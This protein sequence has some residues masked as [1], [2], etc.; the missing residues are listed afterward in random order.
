MSD[1][2]VKKL[3]LLQHRFDNKWS[4]ISKEFLGKSQNL[5]KNT[6]FSTI[7][8]NIR[9]FNRNKQEFERISGPIHELLLI[10]EIRTILETEKSPS[11]QEIFNS[12]LS[13]EVLHTTQKLNQA[14]QENAE[15]DDFEIN[16]DDWLNL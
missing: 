8:R 11:K 15:I 5:L 16:P 14:V 2:D 6:F 10:P 12:S 9:K 1:D 3:F 4:K 13:V 7:R